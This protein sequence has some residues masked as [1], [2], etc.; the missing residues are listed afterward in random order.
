M[1]TTRAGKDALEA[2]NVHKCWPM[3]LSVS[4]VLL[5][6]SRAVYNIIAVRISDVNVFGDGSTFT[7]DMVSTITAFYI[8]GFYPVSGKA[9]WK[10]SWISSQKF[11]LPPKMTFIFAQTDKSRMPKLRKPLD[12]LYLSS[13]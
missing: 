10:L 12:S 8:S 1:Y 5:F 11:E 6:F 2:Q 4:L 13:T 7:T 3:L 9:S